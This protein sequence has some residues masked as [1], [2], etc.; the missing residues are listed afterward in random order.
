MPSPTSDNEIVASALGAES[1]IW[2]PATEVA[3]TPVSASES[4]YGEILKSSAL[5]G[6]S[7]V[8]NVAIGIART[9]AMAMLLGPAGFG[10]AGLYNSIVDL[11]QNIAGMGVNSSGVRQIA[12]AA[13]TD[14]TNQISLTIAVLRRTSVVLGIIGSLLLVLFSRQVS[15]LTFGTRE[16]ALSVCVLSIGVFCKLIS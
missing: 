14:D 13:A 10:L 3:P 6:G 11:A 12:E 15:L 7:Q 8:M 16:H 4:S 1:D 9:K 5:I 2:E